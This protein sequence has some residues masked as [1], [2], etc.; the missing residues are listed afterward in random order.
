MD[1]NERFAW[2]EAVHAAIMDARSL[3]DFD[4]LQEWWRQLVDLSNG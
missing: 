4:G 2:I 1:F 3:E